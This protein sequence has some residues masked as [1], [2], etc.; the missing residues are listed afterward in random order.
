MALDK[1]RLGDAMADRVISF[2]TVTPG[3]ADETA[4]R[5]LMKG[6]A[7]EI[8]DEFTNNAVVTT[9]TSTPGAQAGVSTLP[10]TGTGTVS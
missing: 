6:L 3:G 8:I 5:N 10:G 4:L 7:Q 1:D 2:L 9:T